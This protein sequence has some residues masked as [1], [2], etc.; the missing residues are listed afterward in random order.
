MQHSD[1]QVRMAS[2]FPFP[3]SILDS[4]LS[5]CISFFC[6]CSLMFEL[7][8]GG[9]HWDQC[10]KW[11]IFFVLKLARHLH[12]FIRQNDVY[13]HVIKDERDETF[14]EEVKYIG[15]V[16]VCRESGVSFLVGI[17]KSV[18]FLSVSVRCAGQKYQV[19]SCQ[20]FY[21]CCL[22][23]YYATFHSVCT[24]NSDIQMSNDGH[25]W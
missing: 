4:L 2:L 13:V 22:S 5:K 10:L 6:L 9:S 8:R 11:N 14:G 18:L 12:F 16:K 17:G 24:G 23:F 15:S 1:N 20:P 3:F 21:L 19:K 25:K 7:N